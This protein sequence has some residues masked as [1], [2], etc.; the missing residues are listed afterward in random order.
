MLNFG[1]PALSGQ[2][3]SKVDISV[4]ERSI[5]QAILRFEPR[6]LPKTLEVELVAAEAAAIAGATARHPPSTSSTW[7]G[8]AVS[9][10]HASRR[11]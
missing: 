3:A 5:R 2:Q 4:L 11:A 9:T 1:L 8:P 7:A 6:I 10:H